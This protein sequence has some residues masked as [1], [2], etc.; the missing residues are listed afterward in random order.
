MKY[1]QGGLSLNC[2]VLLFPCS[3]RTTETMIRTCLLQCVLVLITVW[4]R[5]EP[6]V[7]CSNITGTVGESLTLT[8]RVS[9]NEACV[10]EKFKWKKNGTEFRSENCSSVTNLNFNHT[11][12]TASME[13][14]GN[15][16]FWVQLQSDSFKTPFNVTL[17]EIS[18]KKVPTPTAAP[19]PEISTKK[20]ST[21]TAAPSPGSLKSTKEKHTTAGIVIGC[22][23][24]LGII[25]LA[26]YWIKRRSL[27][28]YRDDY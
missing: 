15:Y 28:A 10:C 8:C 19:S 3:S 1:L 16:S 11:I 7:Q 25:V 24:T 23:V 13:D 21:P 20:D 14:S 2:N 26:V 6:S 12:P 27:R 22:G 5:A 17:S 18:T 9:C 4:G